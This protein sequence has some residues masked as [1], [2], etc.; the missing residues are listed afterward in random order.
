M[1]NGKTVKLLLLLAMMAKLITAD[2]CTSVIVS[3]RVTKDGRPMILKNRDSNNY[4]NLSVIVQGEK[5]KYLAIVAAK[6]SL[7]RSVWSGHNEKGFAIINTAAYNLNGKE[8]DVNGGKD[9]RL[10]KRALEICASVEDFEHF[11]DTLPR[12]IGTNSNYGVIDAHGCCAYYETGNS[13]Y[14]KFDANDPHVAPYGY[15]VRTN[16]A[17]S[18][19]RELDK[20]VERYMAMTDFML[21][22]DFCGQINREYLLRGVAR[23][24]K[25]GFSQIDLY[26]QI[27]ES[28]SERTI[29]PFKD[30]IPRYQST[31][32]VLIQGV[33][34]GEDPLLT[35]NWTIV[36]SPLTTVAIPLLITADNR[37]PKVVTRGDDGY[38]WLTKAGLELKDIIFPLKRGN[39]TEYIDLSKLIN[40]QNTGIL[41]KVLGIEDVVLK[42]GNSVVDA[43]R[44]KGRADKNLTEYYSW[45]DKY[46]VEQYTEQFGIEF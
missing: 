24:L 8:R 33:K 35:V 3:G 12:P 31:S 36:G 22:A 37:L 42:R 6:D 14:T 25:H 43:I 13:G 38:A 41:Q 34:Q 30:F 40:R 27:P 26:K 16:H 7:P 5:Y 11:L 17:Q 23:N 21:N 29:V 46:I 19:D 28:E 20:G 45:V 18:G 1:K 44:E 10:M 39:Y 32:C 15:L 2:A 9:G 4:D